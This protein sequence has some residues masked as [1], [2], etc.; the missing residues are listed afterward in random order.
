[1]Q[2]TRAIEAHLP[3]VLAALCMQHMCARTRDAGSMARCGEVEALGDIANNECLLQA[4]SGGHVSM[5]QRLLAAGAR[6]LPAGFEAACREGNMNIVNMLIASGALE[7]PFAMHFAMCK[8][9][10]TGQW[11][12]IRLLLAHGF[13]SWDSAMSSAC[14]GGHVDVV[15]FMIDKGASRW[16]HGLIAA[17][18]RG[19]ADI[20]KL[21]MGKGA[22]R[23][24]CSRGHVDIAKIMVDSGATCCH[25]C[26]Q[27][28]CKK[29]KV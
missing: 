15:H 20:V 14:F 24:A 6:G 26:G 2:T 7:I 29:I 13:K 16:E 25:S 23:F 18:L 19:H 3:S 22:L 21:M 1:M 11:R 17:C 28:S 12:V 8:A 9:C 5:V 10:D 4:C 27:L